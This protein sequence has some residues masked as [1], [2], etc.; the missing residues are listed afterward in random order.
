[1]GFEHSE[2]P[3]TVTE[4][5]YIFR[6]NK[7]KCTRVLDLRFPRKR[8]QKLY[9]ILMKNKNGKQK[10]L[11]FIFYLFLGVRKDTRYTLPKKV[12]KWRMFISLGTF[13]PCVPINTF[14]IRCAPW[15]GENVNREE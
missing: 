13:S 10:V 7:G 4:S 12:K 14:P 9:Y 11:R 15:S 2:K 1:M 5:E 8:S 3:P 6:G